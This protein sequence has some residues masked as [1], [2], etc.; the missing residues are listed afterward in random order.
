MVHLENWLLVLILVLGNIPIIKVSFIIRTDY[1]A[2]QR[3]IYQDE[4]Y[5][6]KSQN[7]TV[8]DFDLD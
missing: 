3:G 6:E 5:K 2:L 8:A 1:L 4:A 7:K